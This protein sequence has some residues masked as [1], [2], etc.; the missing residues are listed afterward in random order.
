MKRYK[1]KSFHGGW[2]IVVLP[3]LIFSAFSLWWMGS[4]A[5]ATLSKEVPPMDKKF[6]EHFETATFALG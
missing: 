6:T 3:L 2:Q 4:A 5:S 1:N